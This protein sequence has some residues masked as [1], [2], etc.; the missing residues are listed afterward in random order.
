MVLPGWKGGNGGNTKLGNYDCGYLTITE[1]LW[2]KNR[3]IEA[4]G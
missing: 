3:R 2:L 1:A 4:V